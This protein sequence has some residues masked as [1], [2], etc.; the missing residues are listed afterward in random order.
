MV[1]EATDVEFAPLANYRIPIEGSSD[2]YQCYNRQQS[3]S[4]FVTI[5]DLSVRIYVS[6]RCD[7]YTLPA[8]PLSHGKH[9][10]VFYYECIH[11]VHRPSMGKASS[12]S[13]DGLR[14]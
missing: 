6:H 2:S 12:D 9:C 13:G 3:R 1:P 5:L 11:P 10:S 8:R 7:S 14:L 4:K